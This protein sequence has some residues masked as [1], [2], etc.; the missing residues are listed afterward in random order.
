MA[1]AH[2]V[3]GV[4]LDESGGTHGGVSDLGDAVGL[5]GDG[6]ILEIVHQQLVCNDVAQQN[7]GPAA[8]AAAG[9]AGDD[10]AQ[11]RH[12]LQLHVPQAHAAG[13]I[14]VAADNGIP[15]GHAGG[16]DGHVAEGAAQGVIAGLLEGRADEVG[17][18]GGH[19]APADVALGAEGAVVIPADQVVLQG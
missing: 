3:G 10:A 15:Q 9:A 18:H 13:D 8:L 14:Q 16:G 19:F 5:D 12:V 11:D 2:A 1:E 6:V 4:V 17:H 7:A